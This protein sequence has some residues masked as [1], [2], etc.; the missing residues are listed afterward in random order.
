MGAVMSIEALLRWAYVFELPKDEHGSSGP[1]SSPSSWQIVERIGELGT[2]VDTFG[3]SSFGHD[4]EPHPDALAIA[5][6]VE[7]LDDEAIEEGEAHDLLAGWPDFGMAG[8]AAVARAWSMVTLIEDGHRWL[9]SPL[10]A[11][12]RRAAILGVWP[13]WRCEQPQSGVEMGRNGRPKWFRIVSCPVEWAEDGTVLRTAEMEVDGYNLIRRQPYAGA[14]RKGV[15][16]PDPAAALARRI[17]YGLTHAAL[18]SL[19]CR[20]DGLG[21]RRVTSPDVGPVPWSTR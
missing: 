18:R 12:V 5:A 10:S 11:L 4:E 3:G 19:A 15:L 1:A 2:M 9:R 21:G 6:A 20:L 8:E 7:A 17:E 13:E 16:T 14:Y